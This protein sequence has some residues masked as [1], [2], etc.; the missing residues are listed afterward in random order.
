MGIG[1]LAEALDELAEVDPS[2]LADE[3]TIR[4]LQR[5]HARQAAV[6]ARAAAAYD[7]KKDWAERH[8]RSAATRLAYVSHLPKTTCQRQ[9]RLG[10]SL[11]HMP[12]I[13]QL[14]LSGDISEAHVA[15]LASARRRGLEE[16]FAR[17]ENVLASLA[18]RERF[19]RFVAAV[20]YW[21]QR[22][23]PDGDDDDALKK[24]DR[25]SCHLSKSFNGM[26]FGDVTLDPLGGA[27]VDNELRRIERA[28]FEADW[29]EA[30]ERLGRDPLASELRRSSAQRLADALCEMARRS[31]RAPV[32]GKD[33]APLFTVL[34]GWETLHDRICQLDDGT[35][36]SPGAL[37]P[38]LDEARLQ[39]VVFDAQS[40]PIDVGVTQRLFTGATRRAIEVRDL[41]CYEPSCD[42]PARRCQAD[43][44]E[45]WSMGGPTTVDNGRLACGFHNRARHRHMRRRGDPEA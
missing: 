3:E 17:D 8:A 11:R 36:V 25:R 16:L 39:R 7:A 22:A 33:P 26:W 9:V 44:V 5:Q 24:F 12:V 23:D 13:E 28:M 15:V 2:E 29:A 27:V 41:E 32:G 14:W 35:V 20:A 6:I 43:H 45:P 40:R 31:G 18:R 1:A 4:Q 38:W 21:L 37:V 42:V 34:I 19:D 10:R 30:T